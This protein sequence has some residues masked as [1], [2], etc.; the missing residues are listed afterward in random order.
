MNQN[1]ESATQSPTHGVWRAAL[2]AGVVASIVFQVLE[3]LLIPRF[4]G[5]SPWGPARM[6]AAMVM[7][8][9]VLPP[10]ATFDARI[11]V[12][13]LAVD[14]V[15]AVIYA[16]L[17]G[18]IIRRWT[19]GRSLAVAAVFGALLYGINFYGFTVI[20]PWFVMGRNGVTLFTHVVFSLTAALTFKRL[21]AART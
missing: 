7:G 13:A 1:P 4:G 18:A 6:I 14:I 19:L 17:L 11:V 3:I 9:G 21:Q 10:P 16:A 5:G 12:V 2:I 15:L 20:F 8:R